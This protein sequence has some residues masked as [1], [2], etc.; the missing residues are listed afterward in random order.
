MENRLKRNLTLKS[1]RCIFLFV[2]FSSHDKTVRCGGRQPVEGVGRAAAA[3]SDGS[4]C[5]DLAGGG[6]CVRATR[7]GWAP[8]VATVILKKT[9]TG[10]QREA[11]VTQ[12]H[13]ITIIRQHLVQRATLKQAWRFSGIDWGFYFVPILNQQ[14]DFASFSLILPH[15][16]QQSRRTIRTTNVAETELKFRNLC[17]RI[18]HV[19]SVGYPS[20]TGRGTW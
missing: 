18:R 9:D 15:V 6:R 5:R 19:G 20:S 2:V 7:T 16:Q 4:A 10:R 14:C 8:A 3:E 11:A 13:T 12:S 17:I 1:W